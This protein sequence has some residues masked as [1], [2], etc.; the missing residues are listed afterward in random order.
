METRNVLTGFKF[1]GDQIGL[2]EKD[3]ETE[4]IF[5][6][7]ESCGYLFGSYIRDKNG[8][9]G[10]YL[11][12]EM[13][14]FYKTKGVSQVEKLQKQYATHGFAHNTLQSYTSEG[15][16]G[17]TKMQKTMSKIR[18]EGITEINVGKVVKGID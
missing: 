4:D 15:A 3:G 12:A 6:S 1:I 17:F 10:A 11:I 16:S 7:E 13:F 5:G 2:L 18:K 14:S 9:N 8:V